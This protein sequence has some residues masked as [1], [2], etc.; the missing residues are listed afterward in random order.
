MN[1]LKFQMR[2]DPSMVIPPALLPP[3]LTGEMEGDRKN[4]KINTTNGSID[5]D[6]IL[7]GGMESLGI[8]DMKHKKR[9]TLD[10]NSENGPINVRLVSTRLPTLLS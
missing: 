2:Q 10:V 5:V 9:T 1:A 3:L 4:L 8:D 7:V 6:V